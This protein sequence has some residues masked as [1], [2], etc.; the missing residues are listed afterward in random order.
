MLIYVSCPYSAKTQ[1]EKEA[2][3]NRA[4]QAGIKI[5]QKG[6][7]PIIPTLMHYLDIAAQKQGI[8]FAY[9]VFMKACIEILDGCDAM[10]YMDSSNGCD[11]ELEY[12]KKEAIDIFYNLEEIDEK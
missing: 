12:A 3:V 5:M 11:I 6:H 2:N 4:I 10:L 8:H 9:D 1:Q 7:T